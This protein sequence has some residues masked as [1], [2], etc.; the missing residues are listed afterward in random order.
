MSFRPTP[1]VLEA[2]DRRAKQLNR[3]RS[4][5]INE[6]VEAGLKAKSLKKGNP[7]VSR[8]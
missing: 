8:N 3:S 7:D 2:I 5:I 6:L 1:D 4:W